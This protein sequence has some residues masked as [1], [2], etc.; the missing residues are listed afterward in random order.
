MY[1]L[2]VRDTFNFTYDN[3]FEIDLKN[4]TQKNAQKKYIYSKHIKCLKLMDN[5]V[6]NR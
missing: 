4:K 6:W 1:P 2:C 3:E 5:S